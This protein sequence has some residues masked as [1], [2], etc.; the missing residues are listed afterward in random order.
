MD[1]KKTNYFYIDE[2]GNINNN[3]NIFI[4]GCIKT[5]SPQT[6]TDA[7]VKL[8]TDIQSSIYYDDIKKI[9][10]KQGFHATE[11][12]MDIRAEVYKILPLLDYRAYFVITNK[13]TVFFKEKM[14]TMDESDFFAYSLKKLLKDRI[15]AHRYEKNIFIFETI[16]L[17]R[18]SLSRVLTDFFS[19]Y[20]KKIDCEFSIVGKEEENL[21]IVD[22]LN[23]LFYHI[24]SDDK[25]FPR[26]KLNFNLVAPKIALVNYSHKNLFFSRQKKEEFQVSLQNLQKNY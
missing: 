8:K 19:N 4:H 24:F 20:D 2:S 18:N 5:D 11:N 10:L 9:I 13:N 14:K 1:E 26:M 6:I 25:P 17:K 3:S 12:N 7:L 23:F 21:A 15:E 22:Y 16:E